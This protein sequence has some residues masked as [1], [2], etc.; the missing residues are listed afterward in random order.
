MQKPLLH[1]RTEL[2]LDLYIKN[3]YHGL[4]LAGELGMGKKHIATWLADQL[5]INSVFIQKAEDKTAITIEQIRSLYDLT[6]TGRSQLVT[7]VDAHELGTDAQNAFLKLL[8]EPPANVYFVLTVNSANELLSTI[9]SRARIVEVYRPSELNFIDYYKN[10]TEDFIKLVRTANYLPG[11]VS[12]AV[13]DEKTKV[14]I[15]GE[16]ND[17]KNFY[18]SDTYERIKYLS[19]INYEKDKVKTL[20]SKLNQIIETLIKINAD[21]KI[22]LKKLTQQAHETQEAL[23]SVFSKPGNIK[24]HLI[25]LCEML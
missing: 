9:R 3:P 14:T 7:L 13:A 11:L 15:Q 18:I 17:A 16:M 6:K 12:K 2:Q 19:S 24:I 23:N 21:N 20:L 25:K 4:I 5:G 1:P 10:N 8:E 22:K